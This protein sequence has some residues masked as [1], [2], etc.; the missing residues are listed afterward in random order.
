MIEFTSN[1]VFLGVI[2]LLLNL[3]AFGAFGYD[4]AKASYDKWRTPERTLLILAFFGPF[5]AYAS[6]MVFRHKT[7]KK[8]FTWMVPLFVLIHLVLFGILFLKNFL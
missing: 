8:P 2:Y 1:I 6:M 5:G 3:I 7:Q 4:K